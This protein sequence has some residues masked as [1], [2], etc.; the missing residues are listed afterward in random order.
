MTHEL[1]ELLGVPSGLQILDG[2]AELP[3]IL[4]RQVDPAAARVGADVAN[5]VRQLERRAQVDRVLARPRIG[6]AKDLDAAE[7]DGRGHPIAIR[8]QVFGGLVACAIEIH[9]DPVDDR[10]ERVARDR[11]GTHRLRQPCR[12]RI[13]RGSTGLV[14]ERHRAAPAVERAPLLR[15]IGPA[16]VAEIRDV[17]HGPAEGVHGVQ[18]I[19]ARLGQ[20]EKRVEEVRAAL[21]RQASR[22]V[23]D[24]AVFRTRAA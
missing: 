6:V 7:A 11:E 14:A 13:G 24:H 21:A 16:L 5:D 4:L 15:A 12:D 20:R 9:R 3:Q 8:V 2:H 23:S 10:Q 22:E 1:D 18:R 17:V 19:A